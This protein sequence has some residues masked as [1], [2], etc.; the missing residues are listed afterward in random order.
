MIVVEG[1]LSREMGLNGDRWGHG[2]H[3]RLADGT[4]DPR[5]QLTLINARLLRRLSADEQRQSLAGDQLVVDLDLSVANLPIGQRLRV[6]EAVIEISD[7]PHNGCHKFRER[8]GEAALR[9]VNSPRGKSMR[10]RGVYA[11][12]ESRVRIRQGDSIVKLGKNDDGSV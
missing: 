8:F 1:E 9:L 5:T 3:K 7:I 10:L 12:V 4:P 2:S 6:G 11:R